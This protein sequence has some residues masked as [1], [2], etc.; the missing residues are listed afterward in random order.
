M[1][2]IKEISL[3]TGFSVATISRVFDVRYVDKVKKET[4]DKILSVCSQYDYQPKASAKALASGK[5]FTIGLVLA[6]IEKDFASPFLAQFHSSLARELRSNSYYFNFIPV[7]DDRPEL[8]DSE[9]L[10]TFHSCGVDGFITGSSM[11]GHSSLR[12]LLAKKF[13]VVAITMPSSKNLD[14]DVSEVYI[15]NRP[16]TIGLI[17]H[18]TGLGH[19][20]IAYIKGYSDSDFRF[21]LF[22]SIA[23][24][25]GIDF[26]DRDLFAM[27]GINTGNMQTIYTTY[28]EIL[29]NWDL[30]KNHTAWVC[31][32][33]LMAIGVL[34][35][36]KTKGVI[37]GKDI[38]VAGYDNIEENSNYICSEPEL[39]TIA[40][41]IHQMG[42]ES[43]HLILKLCSDRNAVCKTV[44]ETK[45][46]IRKSTII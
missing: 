34:N 4:R 33:D 11:I 43:A 38:A 35:A 15:D 31:G 5:T 7:P 14:A 18:L 36:M 44:L 2:S 28:K 3:K 46:I 10:K 8:I 25:A 26:T 17:K 21:S 29:S 6:S 16:G 24:E 45:L 41:P 22:K 13:P 27:R 12:E 1:L 40:P 19:R 39:T 9:L 23:C 30:L 32:N 20:R 37:P 42:V